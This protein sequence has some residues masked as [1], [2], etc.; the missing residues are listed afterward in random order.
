MTDLWENMGD[1]I[2]G[3]EEK[4]S[5]INNLTF[6][7]MLDRILVLNKPAFYRGEFGSIDS[8]WDMHSSEFDYMNPDPIK[9]SRR[10]RY[11]KDTYEEISTYINERL[12]ILERL[13]T[14]QGGESS[15]LFEGSDVVV[16]ESRVNRLELPRNLGDMTD[17]EQ[18]VYKNVFLEELDAYNN[19]LISCEDV[20]GRVNPI[21]VS[22][23]FKFG[24]V[25]DINIDFLIASS[26]DHLN[27]VDHGY[28][29]GSNRTNSSKDVVGGNSAPRM[30]S[31]LLYTTDIAKRKRLEAEK[32]EELL[33]KGRLRSRIK[34]SNNKKDSTVKKKSVRN[35]A[36]KKKPNINSRVLK[37]KK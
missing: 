20:Y 11:I 8:S 16:N 24:G 9:R 36:V 6:H 10:M 34:K 2:F 25:L 13:S 22:G 15:G 12:Q 21:G 18:E 33:K 37:K 3:K 19:Y 27:P 28:F 23:Y 7:T 4:A 31:S 32:K 5:V 14:S 35:E 17:I 26:Q 29:F 30:N 1:M